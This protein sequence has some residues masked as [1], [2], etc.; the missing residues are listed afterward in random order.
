MVTE[1]PQYEFSHAAKLYNQD[2][3]PLICLLPAVPLRAGI[4]HHGELAPTDRDH[5]PYADQVP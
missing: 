3:V 1:Q 4:I 2:S 5:C